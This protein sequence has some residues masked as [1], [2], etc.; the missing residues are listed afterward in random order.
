MVYYLIQI[1][2]VAM[3]MHIIMV[4]YLYLINQKLV[5]L[6]LKLSLMVLVEEKYDYSSKDANF[7]MQFIV[8][9]LLVGQRLILKQIEVI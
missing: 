4:A 9:L 8:V 2:M 3:I 5:K 6:N 7:P 1:L